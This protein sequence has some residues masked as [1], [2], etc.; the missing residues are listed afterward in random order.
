VTAPH[1]YVAP[2][3]Q[4]AVRIQKTDGKWT[5]A[6]LV[7]TLA[8]DALAQ[9]VPDTADPLWATLYAYDL[10]SGGLETINRNDKQGLALAKRNK[11][12]FQAQEMLVLLAQLAHNLL[13]WV[14]HHLARVSPPMQHFGLLR[15]VRDVLHVPGAL[16]YDS[17]GNPLEFSLSEHHPLAQIVVQ[18]FSTFL[19]RD[20]LCL[21]LRQI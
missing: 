9:L 21:N 13:I 16:V 3:Q 17:H 4:L 2:T 8:A 1:P 20:D 6:V 5:Y 18:A 15:L 12:L 11:R 7:S 14:R 10:R 19:A